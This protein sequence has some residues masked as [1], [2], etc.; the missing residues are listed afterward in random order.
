MGQ[1]LFF[2]MSS[3]VYYHELFAISFEICEIKAPLLI[4]MNHCWNHIHVW[5]PGAMK[6]WPFDLMLPHRSIPYLSFTWVNFENSFQIRNSLKWNFTKEHYCGEAFN[7]KAS[8]LSSIWGFHPQKNKWHSG[9]I[10]ILFFI[11]W[12]LSTPWLAVLALTE[13]KCFC[14]FNKNEIWISMHRND[15]SFQTVVECLCVPE[16]LVLRHDIIYI[17]FLSQYIYMVF[18][19]VNQ[20]LGNQM[21]WIWCCFV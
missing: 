5:K 4:W 9:P 15:T 2:H 18:I 10:Y 21:S 17:W 19:P 14:S 7:Q 16:I 12:I 1:R 20:N 11:L 8:D 3:N 6:S 13:R